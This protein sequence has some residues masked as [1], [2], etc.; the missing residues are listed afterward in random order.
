MLFIEALGFLLNDSSHDV[1]DGDNGLSM[2]LIVDDPYTMIATVKHLFNDGAKCRFVSTREWLDMFLSVLMKEGQD[3]E[4][5]AAKW[6]GAWIVVYHDCALEIRSTEVAYEFV[7]IIDDG[8]G[9][10]AGLLHLL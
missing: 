7:A 5:K 9:R 2:I 4:K 1:S 10:D 6:F 8:Q 3:G